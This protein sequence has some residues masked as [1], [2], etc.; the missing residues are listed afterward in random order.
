MPPAHKFTKEEIVKAALE[1]VRREGIAGLTAR[2]LGAELGVSSRPV[3]TAFKNME[4]VERETF[5]AAREI[6]NGYVEKGLAETIA[7]KGVGMR[8]IRFAREEPKLFSLLFM[9]EGESTPGLDSVLPAID[10]NNERI[11]ASIEGSY[12]LSRKAAYKLYQTL[13]IL[14]HGIACLCATGV[15]RL[16]EEET[17]EILTDVFRSLFIK[18]KSEGK[19][20]A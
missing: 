5:S 10:A 17:D 8:Y 4:E 7:F 19:E 11:L 1:L 15:S 20:N 3:F 14:S 9:T 13:W 12:G 2:A 18:I 16:T 6:Y